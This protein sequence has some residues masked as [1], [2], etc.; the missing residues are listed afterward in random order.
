MTDAIAKVNA[1][2]SV[3][4]RSALAELAAYPSSWSREY[5]RC[6]VFVKYKAIPR[7]PPRKP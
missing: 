1:L 7:P 6:R 3:R 4:L 2:A 5:N